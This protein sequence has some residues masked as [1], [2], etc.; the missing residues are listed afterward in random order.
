[1]TFFTKI[2][3]TILRFVW[4]HKRSQIGK[5]I[6]SKKN[7]AKFITL[8][9]FKL[10]YKGILIKTVWYWHK[11]K[12]IDQCNKIKS[13]EKKTD[14]HGKLIYDKGTK[15]IQWGKDSLMN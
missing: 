6:L 2:E 4:N 3:Q 11:N 10:Y 1:M 9:D 8:P 7:I 12:H 13:P 14:K 5:A 15:N